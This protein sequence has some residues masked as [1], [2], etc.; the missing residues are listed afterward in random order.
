[1]LAF[2]F[3]MSEGRSA[4]FG[5]DNGIPV[6]EEVKNYIEITYSPDPVLYLD[7]QNLKNGL[8]GDAFK[9]R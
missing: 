7:V 8:L 3:P 5:D 6:R 4:Q 2:E 1:M 9:F